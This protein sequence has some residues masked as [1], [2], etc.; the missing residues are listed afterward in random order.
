M[1]VKNFAQM[2]TKK[3]EKLLNEPETTDEE[4][5]A[6]Q[7]VLDKRAELNGEAVDGAEALSDEE[8]AAINAA[9]TKAEAETKEKPKKAGRPI[10]EK[11]S[12]EE[13]D[14]ICAK[15]KAEA[16]GHRCKTTLPS[17]AIET[18]GYIKSVLKEKRAMACYL[19]VQPDATIDNPEPKAF[20]KTIDQVEILPEVVELKKK[21]DAKIRK[22]AQDPDE[23]SINADKVVEIAGNYVGR[24]ANLGDKGIGHIETIIKDKRAFAVFFRVGFFD[25]NGAHKF[26]HKSIHYNVDEAEG[27]VT[28]EEPDWLMPFDE[29]DIEKFT[30]LQNK[31]QT[32][33]ERAPRVILTLEEKLLRAEKSLEKAKANLEKAQEALQIKQNEYDILR[34]RFDARCDAKEANANGEGVAQ[35]EAETADTDLM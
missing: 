3:L 6:I 8:V 28:I 13:L 30:E 34:A 16:L 5:V 23:W 35:T 1:A 7:A 2:G 18:D 22:I 20:Y 31:W 15:A 11:I 10:K 14:A 27:K 17:S 9:E 21:R 32:R 33:G 19:H 4:K 24:E 25:E 26:T 12:M 29:T